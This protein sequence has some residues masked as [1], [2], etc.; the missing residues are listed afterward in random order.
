MIKGI[1]NRRRECV[2]I[3]E[4]GI[5]AGE[6]LNILQEIERP[7]CLEEVESLI[8]YP[9][10]IIIMA[11]GW[12]VREGHIHVRQKDNKRYICCSLDDR[13]HCP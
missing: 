3:T 1:K 2:I 10:D 13:V 4:L 7:V 9:K 8:N 12:L 11:F 6:I 5:I